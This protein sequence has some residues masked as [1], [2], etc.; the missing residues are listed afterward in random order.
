MAKVL[1][2]DKDQERGAAGDR[3]SGHRGRLGVVT[4]AGRGEK[5]STSQDLRC[6][7]KSKS[8]RRMFLCLCSSEAAHASRRRQASSAAQPASSGRQPS[9]RSGRSAAFWDE[10]SRNML[11]KINKRRNGTLQTSVRMP[12]LQSHSTHH[13]AFICTPAYT[14]S[15]SGSKSPERGPWRC[16]FI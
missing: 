12:C 16:D 9:R 8:K 10:K 14:W 6:H 2:M 15:M 11:I 13:V 5:H 3:C 7:G 1:G 4:V